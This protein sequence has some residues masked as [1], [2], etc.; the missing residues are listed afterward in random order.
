[1]AYH[2]SAEDKRNQ[3]E[4][5]DMVLRMFPDV[6]D[7]YEFFPEKS[8][9]DGYFLKD[10]K[11]KL[12]FEIKQ[13]WTAYR[14]YPDYFISWVKVH[15]AVNKLA[16]TGLRTVAFVRFIDNVLVSF[17]LLKDPHTCR[18]AART[19]EKPEVVAVYEWADIKV[20]SDPRRVEPIRIMENA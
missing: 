1:M 2:E 9:L 19:G 12:F 4:I 20:L 13:R 7:S 14:T 16:E 6:F 15:A 10:G 3:R 5:A 8:I 18:I 17:D 11:R